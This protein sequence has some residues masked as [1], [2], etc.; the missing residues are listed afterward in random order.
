VCYLSRARVPETKL[1]S[2]DMRL[3]LAG[4]L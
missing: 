4:E 1:M 2:F 3:A